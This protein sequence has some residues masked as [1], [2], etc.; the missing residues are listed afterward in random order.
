[1]INR[2]FTLIVPICSRLRGLWRLLISF[3]YQFPRDFELL[4]AGD[5]SSPAVLNPNDP[6]V[7]IM[8][9]QVS[10][11]KTAAIHLLLGQAIG[12]YMAFFED[13]DEWNGRSFSISYRCT[14][15]AV[16][17]AL[18]KQSVHG[19]DHPGPMVIRRIVEFPKPRKRDAGH[20]ERY[21]GSLRNASWSGSVFSCMRRCRISGPKRPL[22]LEI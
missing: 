12:R 6:R 11:G 9:M 10:C 4:M 19:D 14:Y 22:W 20:G 7:R 8:I 2:V 5:D 13:N 3:F 15:A 16:V 17:R 18:W 1:M 21:L